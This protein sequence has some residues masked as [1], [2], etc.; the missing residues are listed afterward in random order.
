MRR[1]DINRE[2]RNPRDASRFQS[3]IAGLARSTLLLMAII[4]PLGFSQE[5]MDVE[6]S[7]EYKVKAAFLHKFFSYV[8]WPASRLPAKSKS[9]TLGVIGRDPF[10]RVLDAVTKRSLANRRRVIVRRFRKVEDVKDC[11][12]LFVSRS[13]DAKQRDYILAKAP[14]LGIL[15]ISE[16]KGFLEKGGLLNFVLIDNKVRFEANLDAASKSGLRISSKLLRHAHRIVKKKKPNPK[17]GAPRR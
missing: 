7:V 6:R 15:T 3:V 12:L 1:H 17:K 10:G 5:R 14:K 16:Q 2:T 13:L 9:I 4:V 8:E 11:H